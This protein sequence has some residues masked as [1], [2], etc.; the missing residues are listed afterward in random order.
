M[1]P[2]KAASNKRPDIEKML[3]E[4]N[5]EF[6]FIEGLSTSRFNRE[7][8]LKN[9]ARL[10]MTLNKETVERYVQAIDNGDQFP[11]VIAHEVKGKLVILDGNHRLNAHIQA[12]API[13]AYICSGS[14]QALTML[15]FE[16]NAKHGL[17]SS[18]E[19]RLHHG[20][21]LIDSGMRIG[22]AAKRLGVKENKLRTAV[23]QQLA[24]RRAHE[25][26]IPRPAW[27]ALPV[28]IRSRLGNIN[29]DEGFK[30]MA[31]LALDARLSA[32]DINKY[33][34]I[35]NETRAAG[36]QVAMVESLRDNLKAQIAEAAFKGG[37][38]KRAGS[39]HARLAMAVGQL[40]GL[41]EP[42]VIASQV[43]ETMRPDVI[44]RLDEAADRIAAIK[45][46]LA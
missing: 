30:A 35:I 19:D 6:E 23:N 25:V 12:T 9:Q 3:A 21:F 26:G 44:R 45:K 27:D 1:A 14:G 31:M 7:E 32:D 46:A 4:R 5:I 38:G 22:E 28:S 18:E 42:S 34:P 10:G 17:P 43:P 20:L 39:T 40:V 41:P 8:S 11:P 37:Q 33:V 13:D 29:T 2:R 36:R 24:N 16:A 15:T